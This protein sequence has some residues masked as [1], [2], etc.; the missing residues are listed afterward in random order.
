MKLFIGSLFILIYSF[1]YSQENEEAN[2]SK[3]H[4]LSIVVE[5]FFAK[6]S[7]SYYNDPYYYYNYRAYGFD[8]TNV[9]L[10]YRFHLKK[11]AIRARVS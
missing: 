11:T 1:S 5:D 7:F 9:G 6:N 2:K 3:K 8:V 4:E 10:G